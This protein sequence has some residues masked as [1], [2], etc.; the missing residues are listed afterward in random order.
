MN[1]IIFLMWLADLSEN[2]VTVSVPGFIIYGV[3]FL[4]SMMIE[5]DMS[6]KGHPPRSK[7]ILVF[8]VVMCFLC[9]FFPSRTTLYTAAGL[10][11]TSDILESE[12]GQKAVKLLE[13]K[14]EE[15]SE[16]E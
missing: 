6:S 1:D 15:L 13:D 7:K 4:F 16:N 14:L 11:V 9:M 2:L 5:N 3:Y 10:S 12:A 8:F